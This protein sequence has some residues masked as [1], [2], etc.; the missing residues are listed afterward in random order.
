MF[1]FEITLFWIYSFY[2]D[3]LR[4]PS[5]GYIT[6]LGCDFSADFCSAISLNG[7]L[8]GEWVSNYEFYYHTNNGRGTKIWF[9]G[10]TFKWYRYSDS[11]DN[12]KAQFNA[13]RK[14]YYWLAL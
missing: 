7:I 3:N 2:F 4:N 10:N 6:I 12:S 1:D 14:K 9:Q 5:N 8:K 11:G 13:N